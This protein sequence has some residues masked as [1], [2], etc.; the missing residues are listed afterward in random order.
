MTD[1]YMHLCTVWRIMPAFK[2]TGFLVSCLRAL[3]KLGFYCGGG[4]QG[5]LTHA[6]YWLCANKPDNARL[7][8]TDARVAL[9]FNLNHLTWLRN[10][11]FGYSLSPFLLKTETLKRPEPSSSPLH[12]TVQLQVW[13]GAHQPSEPTRANHCHRSLTAT[14][15][16]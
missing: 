6:S 14:W 10:G 13:L 4:R 2:G 5:G 16:C 7:E 11:S 1:V 15:L 3:Q 12:H 8:T 9:A